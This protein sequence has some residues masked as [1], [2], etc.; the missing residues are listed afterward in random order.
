[1]F[2]D[3]VNRKVS[4][5]YLLEFATTEASEVGE[6]RPASSPTGSQFIFFTPLD[7]GNLRTRPEDVKIFRMP[8]PERYQRQSNLTQFFNESEEQTEPTQ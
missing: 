3:M 7:L 8:D 1:M 6:E 4:M 5:D 2:M